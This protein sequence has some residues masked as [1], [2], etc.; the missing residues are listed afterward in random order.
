[1]KYK[2]HLLDK[3]NGQTRVMWVSADSPEQAETQAVKDNPGFVFAFISNRK[4][5]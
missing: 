4:V 2:V 1:M 3:F 5:E